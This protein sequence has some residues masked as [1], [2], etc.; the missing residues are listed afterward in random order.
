MRRTSAFT[1][2]ELL[3]VI[4]IIGVLIG[5]LLPA[6]QAA[7]ESARR[8]TC[9][10]NMRQL[11][12]AMQGFESARGRL[13]SI[14]N[15]LWAAFSAQAQLLPYIEQ[16][17]LHDLVDFSVP[18]GH[19]R[20]EVNEVHEVPARTPID[21][22]SCPSDTMPVVKLV[23]TALGDPITYAGS[24]YAYNIGT[25]TGT[26]YKY[27]TE[28]DGICWVDSHVRCRQILDGL[29]H[30][31]AFAETLQGNGMRKLESHGGAPQHFHAYGS[32]TW[33]RKLAEDD[34]WEGFHSA[35]ERWD[36]TRSASWIRGF[37][38][39]SPVIQGFFTP[40][41]RYPD[42]VHGV[43]LV[44]GPRSNHSGGV[45]IVFCDSSVRFIEDE[46]DQEAFRAAWTRDA[47]DRAL[48]R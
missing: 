26:Y 35:L 39:I 22:F 38:S 1:L 37:G 16:R 15:D 41:H 47:A 11:G 33:L 36:G 29:S 8:V 45:N 10:N 17:S 34:D 5:L 7:R 14:D 43:N 13:P 40:N 44:T 32:A 4:A 23:E 12:I 25:G 6:V 46:V 31:V 30:T 20:E 28:T 24:N 21:T 27:R 18:L 2:V 48:D 42:I 19:A 3:V 9:S